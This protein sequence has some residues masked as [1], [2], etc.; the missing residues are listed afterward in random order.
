[1][2]SFWC[3]PYLAKWLDLMNEFDREFTMARLK[4]TRA[5]HMW[6]PRDGFEEGAD[7]RREG[8]LTYG[9]LGPSG[10]RGGGERLI[11]EHL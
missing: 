1:M 4:P 6:V 8:H 11:G 5:C 9:P 2:F 10:G 3:K 7:R